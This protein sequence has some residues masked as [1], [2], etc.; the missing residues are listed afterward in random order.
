MTHDTND[1]AA[2]RRGKKRGG[3]MSVA[4]RLQSQS[5]LS[6]SARRPDE[7]EAGGSVDGPAPALPHIGQYD[8]ATIRII[9]QFLDN[10]GLKNS[11]EALVEETG[12]TIETSAGARIRSSILKGNYDAACSILKQSQDLPPE[13]AKN[14][15]YIIQCFKIADLVRKNRYLDALF[16]MRSVYPLMIQDESANLDFIDSFTKDVM[17]GDTRYQN[18]DVTATRNSQLAFLEE[19]LP[20][21]FILPQN[22]MKSLLNKLHG[23]AVDDKASKLL[24]D[25]SGTSRSGQPYDCVEIWD[26]HTT[27]IYCVKFSRN[28]KLMASG[29]KS[30]AI[31]MWKVD[32]GRLAKIGDLA[33]ITE[34]NI[35]YMEFSTKN[36]FFAVCGESTCK[37]NLT[38]FNVDSRTVFRTL[39]MHNGHDDIV[40]IASFF[41]CFSF[42]TSPDLSMI[43]AGN[44]LGALKVYNLNLSEDHPPIKQVSGFRVRALHGMRD[45]DQFLSVDA[46]NRVRI[47][48]LSGDMNGTTICKEEVTI[49]NMVVH[50]SEKLVLTTTDTNLRL[51]D[52]RTHTLV[53]VFSGACQREEFARYSIHA[54]FGGVHQNFIATGTIGRETTDSLRH[55]DKHQKRNGRVVIWSVEE[56]RPRFTLVGHRGHVNAVSWNPR[57]P[58]M[59]VSGGDD[60]TIRV[61]HL[62]RAET[63]DYSEV[64][65]RMIPRSEKY[66]V[67][68]SEPS[69]SNKGS[70]ES[71]TATELIQELKINSVK[72]DFV[73]DL[74]M[75]KKW[76]EKSGRKP[77]E[78]DDDM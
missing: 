44:E 29:G 3:G 76:I 7:E 27:P 1:D 11:V 40:D 30:N 43:V 26:N 28:G 39:R 72:S 19:L 53:R 24:R 15:S 71:R 20:T 57:D 50:P 32:N 13:T 56:S 10:I 14:A 21:N 4:E 63:S 54:T 75:E 73:S 41:T 55:H 61:W 36:R 64:I 58:T 49:V 8:Q 78:V 59:L 51:W 47:Y 25:E 33:P 46:H 66:P 23:T 69:T 16:T 31:T 68:A 9:A 65:P 12:F 6:P 22:R 45:G 34:G 60:R 67:Q 2:T 74:E 77:W 5:Q 48:S 62:D 35:S 37:Y 70:S 17:L 18:V 38:I 52:I 42:L